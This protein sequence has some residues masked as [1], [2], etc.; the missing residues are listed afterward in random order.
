[1]TT[2]EVF[3]DISCPFTHIGLRQI[4]AELDTSTAILV[5]AWPLEWVNGAPLDAASVQAKIDVLRR[6]L[7]TDSFGGLSTKY[8]PRT[9]VPALNLVASAYEQGWRIGLRTSLDVR[10]ALFER[11]ENIGDLD[12]LAALAAANGLPAPE[13]SPAQQVNDDYAE[14]RRRGVKG[15]PDFWLGGEEFFCPS[16]QL[17][18]DSDGDL[19]AQFD[20]NGLARFISQVRADKAPGGPD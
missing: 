5:R 15:S 13:M 19:T 4:V 3:A 1:M 2:V 17:G 20:T 12:V 10:D 8:W 11:G 9:T 16:L 18:H 6:Q 7:D 14:G